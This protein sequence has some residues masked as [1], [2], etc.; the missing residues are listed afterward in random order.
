MD[1]VSVIE[2]ALVA[3]TAKGVGESAAMAVREAYESL[4]ST[5]LSRLGGGAS[6]EMVLT[7]HEAD[8]KTYAAPLRKK[9]EV[10]GVPKL[11]EEDELIR[12]ARAVLAAA[13][14]EGTRS[15]RYLIGSVSADHGGVAVV[16]NEGP[17]TAGY[18]APGSRRSD[19]N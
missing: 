8:P 1:P 15:G 12:A 13:D 5:L 17:V 18:H 19:E 11:G 7:E 6:T 2:A 9:L 10:A 4:R 3:G 14:P 16:H